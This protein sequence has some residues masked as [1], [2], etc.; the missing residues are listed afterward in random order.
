MGSPGAGM[1]GDP[2]G[3][4]TDESGTGSS[5]GLTSPVVRGSMSIGIEYQ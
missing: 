3:W 4:N 2:G 5:P 1:L